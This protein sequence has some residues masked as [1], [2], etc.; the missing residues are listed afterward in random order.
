[1]S[2]I[3]WDQTNGGRIALATFVD[4]KVRIADPRSRDASVI[5]NVHAG[6]KAVCVEW[7]LNENFIFTTGCNASRG[8]NCFEK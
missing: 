8:K 1:M 7:G 5:E 2:S 6:N 3:C 4:K